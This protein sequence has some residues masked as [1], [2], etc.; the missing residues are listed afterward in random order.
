L[1]T[2]IGL[3]ILTGFFTLVSAGFS[4]RSSRK[5]NDAW[6]AL[7]EYKVSAPQLQNFSQRILDSVTTLA[8]E[9]HAKSQ[10]AGTI[11]I[12]SRYTLP[13]ENRTRSVRWPM[14]QLPAIT[15]GFSGRLQP[16]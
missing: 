15:P 10:F 8:N 13:K 11:D 2:L 14:W 3:A 16:T 7:E 12:F 4:A 1:R 5:V 6:N 9:S